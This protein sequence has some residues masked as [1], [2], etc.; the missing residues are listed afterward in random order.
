MKAEFPGSPRDTG[1]QRP[2]GR[3]RLQHN[4]GFNLDWGD[5]AG[6]HRGHFQRAMS[7]VPD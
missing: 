5:E 3:G 7:N 2:Q 1:E 4:L 6:G